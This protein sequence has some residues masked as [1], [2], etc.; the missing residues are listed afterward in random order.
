MKVLV[1]A[2]LCGV[3]CKYDGKNNF[4]KKVAELLKKG[5]AIPVCPEQL[6]GQSTP[7][8]PHELQ[9][10]T[11][12]EV[13]DGKGKILGPEGD[14]ATGEFIKGAE[15]TLTIAQ[16]TGAVC[17]ILKARS[18]SC[19]KG[20][21]YDGSFSGSKREGNGV[22]TELLLKNGIEVYTEETIDEFYEKYINENV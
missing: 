7:R 5:I 14:D 3:N 12:A 10:T 15:E 19:G 4:N 9:D 17:A 22:T 21:I 16:L 1:S 18:P 11:G 6:G 13:L 2:C 8:A 20:I